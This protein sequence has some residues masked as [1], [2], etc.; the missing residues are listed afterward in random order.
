MKNN[1]FIR[2][3]LFAV[4]LTT[5]LSAQ[6]KGFNYQGIARDAEG[7]PL[8]VTTL[9]VQVGIID[10]SGVY[11]FN[12]ASDEVFYVALGQGLAIARIDDTDDENSFCGNLATGLNFYFADS[13]I[14]KI[15]G[16]YRY[17]DKL[18]DGGDSMSIY[19]ANIGVSWV[20]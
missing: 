11:Y 9:Q 8:S 15:E 17:V 14:F 3:M 12:P 5:N 16:K 13:A 7:N 18:I 19:E 10:V 20:F 2:V 4:L 6:Q 1:H